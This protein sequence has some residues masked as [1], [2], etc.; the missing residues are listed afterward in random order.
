MSYN[1]TNENEGK[2]DAEGK[3]VAS[4]WFVVLAIAFGKDAQ[5]GIDVVFTQRL[6]RQ[7]APQSDKKCT[8]L[9]D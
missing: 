5:T 7:N 2:S 1:H 4:E 8:L 3:N 9:T 6:W